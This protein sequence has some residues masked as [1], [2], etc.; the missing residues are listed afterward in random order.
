[1]AKKNRKKRKDG[2]ATARQQEAEEKNYQARSPLIAHVRSRALLIRYLICHSRL[3][4]AS[5]QPDGMGIGGTIISPL[6]VIGNKS[7]PRG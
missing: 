2:M 7:T 1:M 4:V 6:N 5:W 3:K